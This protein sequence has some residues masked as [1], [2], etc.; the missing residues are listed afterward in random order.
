MTGMQLPTYLAIGVAG[1]SVRAFSES[2]CL[3]I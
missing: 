3:L 2:L 1:T